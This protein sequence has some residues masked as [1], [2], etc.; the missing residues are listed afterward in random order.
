MHKIRKI[1]KVYIFEE[2]SQRYYFLKLDFAHV[3]L[4]HCMI[5][6][7]PCEAVKVH[8]ITY[9]IREHQTHM[10]VLSVALK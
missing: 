8:A 3:H 10:N 7:N 1:P 6:K 4:I 9:S 2:K 5:D